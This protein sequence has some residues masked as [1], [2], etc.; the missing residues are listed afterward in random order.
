MDFKKTFHEVA[1]PHGGF[2][3]YARKSNASIGG[4]YVPV[5][6]SKTKRLLIPMYG[7][8]NFVGYVHDAKSEKAYEITLSSFPGIKGI[9]FDVGKWSDNVADL[10]VVNPRNSGFGA[11]HFS[12]VERGYAAFPKLSAAFIENFDAETRKS[13][14]LTRSVVRRSRKRYS[15]V[16]DGFFTSWTSR[17]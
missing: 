17:I 9:C 12:K 5:G 15:L 4:L 13:F 1:A 7:S 2:A 3:I 14:R 16:G 10:V 6:I 11:A 8:G